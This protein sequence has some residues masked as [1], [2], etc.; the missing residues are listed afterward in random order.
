LI[1]PEQ[2]ATA[3][4]DLDPRDRELLALSLRRRVPD[5]ALASMY[6]VEAPEIARR[7]A[8][9][10]DRLSDA[11]GIQRGEDL[12][13][14]L[15]AL[16]EEEIWSATGAPPA[17]GAEFAEGARAA[18]VAPVVPVASEPGLELL[19][20]R[21]GIDPPEA[22]ARAEAPKPDAGEPD[23]EAEPAPEPSP[24]A[25]AAPG[26]R[27]FPHLALALFGTGIAALLG[28]VALVGATQFGEDGRAA[29]GGAGS[30]DGTRH[31]V[32]AA[33]GPGAAP[34]PSEPQTIS[35][36]STAYARGRTTLYRTPG[37]RPLLRVSA[38]TEWESP[39]VF[40]VVRREGEWLAVLAPELPNGKVGW[41]RVADA[42]LD[43]TTWSLHADLS[44]R[45][46]FVRREGKTVRRMRFAIGRPGNSTPK[47][48][49]AV[50]D[51]LRVRDENSP[52]GC[53]VLALNGHQTN[54]PPDWP[55][56][57]RLAVHATKDEASIGQAASLGCLR[58][59]AGQA[60]W[61][62]ETIPLGAPVFIRS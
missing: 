11:L 14:V 42:R 59:K 24:P 31:F 37:G 10:I 4:E 12:G 47:G 29:E 25:P 36:Y 6:D 50:T 49:F 28:A 38:R 18:P 30:G 23:A 27:R 2:L 33:V 21:E 16:L 58:T 9:A 20:E 62:I 35:C 39:R 7:R 17:P 22:E 8:G 54:L 32:P 34:F 13:A 41:L 60:K 40:G 15:K 56:G 5:D 61:L 19:A 1:N 52:Y 44:K 45:M 26:E 57:D 46:L 3:L 48:R 51:K 55:G 53:C 43:C